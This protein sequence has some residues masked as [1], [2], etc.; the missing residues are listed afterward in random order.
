MNAQGPRLEADY[1][2]HANWGVQILRCCLGLTPVVG[3]SVARLS[4]RLVIDSTSLSHHQRTVLEFNNP[5]ISPIAR[6]F[7][8]SGWNRPELWAILR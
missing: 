1:A 4:G 5:A 2:T 3:N 6:Q 8:Y 7:R